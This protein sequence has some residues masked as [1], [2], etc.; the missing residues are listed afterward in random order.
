[1][2]NQQKDLLCSTWSSAQCYVP[3]WIRGGSRGEWMDT[4][5]CMAESLRGSPE[6]PTTLLI[7]YTPMQNK[8]FK[9]KKKYMVAF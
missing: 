9:G 7:G 1:M 2:G 8:K 5:V 3:A 6:T 4:C